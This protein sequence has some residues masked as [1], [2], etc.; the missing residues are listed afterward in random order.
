MYFVA[1]F[2]SY[3]NTSDLQNSGK[4]RG[5]VWGFVLWVVGFCLFF[6]PINSIPLNSLPCSWKSLQ[7]T[8]P[9]LDT[10]ASMQRSFSHVLCEWRGLKTRKPSLSDISATCISQNQLTAKLGLQPGPRA[11]T[12][13]SQR[14]IQFQRL[15]KGNSLY[16]GIH[17]NEHFTIQ[18]RSSFSTV[19]REGIWEK[20]RTSDTERW[21]LRKDES[22]KQRCFMLTTN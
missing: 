18:I 19:Q 17:L 22:F 12:W 14:H 7:Q 4:S 5:C 21:S 16:T 10:N 15:E 8:L 20:D 3:A 6:V 2:E 9:S 11:I 1:L 13:N